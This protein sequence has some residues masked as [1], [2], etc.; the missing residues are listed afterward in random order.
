LGSSG[1]GEEYALSQNK[2]AVVRF[3]TSELLG[4]GC[5]TSP[6]KLYFN[7]AAGRLFSVHGRRSHL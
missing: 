7:D 6:R 4:H 3:D 1:S 2:L 5:S